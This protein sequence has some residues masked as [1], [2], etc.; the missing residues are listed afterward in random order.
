MPLS[1]RFYL[2]DAAF[3]AVV[4][5]NDDLIRGVD[6]ALRAPTFP[7]YLG[8]R[9]CPPAGP[10]TLGVRDGDLDGVLRE[11]PWVA[12]NWHRRTV[13]E[14]DVRLSVVRDADVGEEGEVVRD[15]PVSFD[16]ESRQY[17][18][19]TV[20]RYDVTVSNPDAPKA[21]H[22]S[23]GSAHEPMSLLGSA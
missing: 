2:S 10:V 3:L 22:P 21:V 6:S 7:L 5:G 13:S 18:W 17:A 20:T 1:Y 11:E 23:V 16:P 12:S 14:R 8:R 15:V 19:R 9:S 4:V